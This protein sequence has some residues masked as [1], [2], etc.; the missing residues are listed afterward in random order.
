MLE[1]HFLVLEIQFLTLVRCNGR[2]GSAAGSHCGLAALS[3]R[4][5]DTTAVDFGFLLARG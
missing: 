4:R 1:I 2:F 5:I 3:F